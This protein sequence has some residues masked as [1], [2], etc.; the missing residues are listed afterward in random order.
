MYLEVV[1][2]VFEVVEQGS[3]PVDLARRV[4]VI[5]KNKLVNNH[6]IIPYTFFMLS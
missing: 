4:R 6:Q 3:D 2:E 1:Y 5:P